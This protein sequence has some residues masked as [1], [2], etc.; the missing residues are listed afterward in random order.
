MKL[1]AARPITSCVR[2]VLPVL[3]LFLASA[4]AFAQ[5]FPNKP[6]RIVVGFLAGTG[7]DVSGRIV[8]QFLSEAFGQPVV[9]ENRPGMASML[10]ARDVSKATPDGYTLFMCTTSSHVTGPHL[11]RKPLYDPIKDFTLIAQVVESYLVA[12]VPASIPPNTLKEFAAW[13]K[14][15]PGKVHYASPGVGGS[16]HLLAERLNQAG[17]L[18]MI[19]VPYK[20]S[21]VQELAGGETQ[22]L[23]G[24]LA[25]VNIGPRLKFLAVSSPKRMSE[26]PNVPTAREAGFPDAETALW[27][28]VC[29]PSNIPKAVVTRLT[30]EIRRGLSRPD[31]RE[32]YA[33]LGTPA[34]YRAPAEFTELAKADVAGWLPII[35]SSGATID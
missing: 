19:H 1:H 26:L 2:I 34:T 15:N 12:A 8:S 28:G 27:Q 14:A 7:V 33:R 18:G 32:R 35:K 4:N 31:V 11:T 16:S 3:A 5:E 22:L 23:F 29:G 20:G 21:G 30:E 17:G 9:V 25:T 13:A 24:L 6:L 10:A